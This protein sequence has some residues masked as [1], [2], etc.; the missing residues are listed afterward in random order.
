MEL[1]VLGSGCG[2][3][4]L[5]RG[6]PGHLVLVEQEPLLFDSGSGTL[7]R[8][9]QYG[10]HYTRLRHV[11]YTHP[12]S[13][14][15]ADLVP[16]IQALRT[17]PHYQRTESLHLYGPKGLRQ[18]LEDLAQAFGAW[19]IAP[20]FPLQIHELSQDRLEFSH[21]TIESQPVAHH[22]S[23]IGYR[24]SG[25]DG[26][27]IVYSGDTDFCPEIIELARQTDLLLL[28]C[29]FADDQKVAGHLTPTEAAQIAA[30][31]GC[32][33]VILTHLYPPYDELERQIVQRFKQWHPTATVTAAQDLMRIRL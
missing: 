13:D 4:S 24:V 8:L 22:R 6:A 12:H 32:K 16:L 10:V 2:I 5:Q 3:P 7:V 19:L 17:T 20:G 26:R 1:I 31:A 18:F 28:E 25:K 14:H 15:T 11:F 23:A 9:L 21:W 29:S 33:Q 30:Q 27:S